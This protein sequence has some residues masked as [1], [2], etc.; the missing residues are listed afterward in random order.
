MT[1]SVLEAPE[2]VASTGVS[3]PALVHPVKYRGDIDGLRA[4][5]V[6]TVI[7]YHL[8]PW[9]LPAGGVGVDI[10]FVISGYLVG[11]MVI[12]SLA[13]GSFSFSDFYLRRIRRILPAFLV[14]ILCTTAV[15]AMPLYPWELT[16]LAKSALA[17]LLCASNI[18]F[19]FTSDYFAAESNT[20]P[21][22]HSWSLG[23]EEQYYI[24]FP[25]VIMAAMKMRRGWINQALAVTI[26]VSLLYSAAQVKTNPVG[27]FY[28]LPS[29]WWELALGALAA[30]APR[31]WF[32]APTVRFVVGVIGLVLMAGSLLLVRPDQG[33]PG[34][35]LLPA[36]TGAALF[37]VSGSAGLSLAHR[38][39]AL[40][41][42]RYTG[43]AS[44]SLYLWHWPIIVLYKQFFF[45]ERLGLREAI[46]ILALTLVLG[47]GSW[48]FV[49]RP[50]RSRMPPRQ[51]L[52]RTGALFALVA[53]LQGT[54]LLGRG[55]PQR[56]PAKALALASMT[57]APDRFPMPSRHCFLAVP[58]TLAQYDPRCL[59][60][61]TGKPDW[62]LVGDSH[63]A[64]LWSGLATNLPQIH[65]QT[66]VVFGCEIYLNPQPD[67]RIC[68]DLMHKALVDHIDQ[69][70]PAA[71]VLTWRWPQ[72]D[73]A[74]LQALFDRL[75]R[76]NVQLIVI[77]PTPE[78]GMAVPR[79]MAESLRRQEPDLLYKN[80][81]P[82][83]WGSDDQLRRVSKRIGFTYLSP[84]TTMCRTD[85]QCDVTDERGNMLYFDNNHYGRLGSAFAI[86]KLIEA[87][88][89]NGSPLA[90]A[91]QSSGASWVAPG[92]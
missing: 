50:F 75:R 76:K 61:V 51:L 67:G 62:L 38:L 80:L 52:M 65:F 3:A 83:I 55:F 15:A 88:R 14:M 5:A 70:P 39:M 35:V 59:G 10:F 45:I 44:Y 78:Y 82:R 13:T 66:A 7:L 25:F 4:L 54:F 68:N 21:L 92:P 19:Y 1:A 9:R 16:S 60:S 41:P 29:R 63:A 43:L 86:R 84:L 11:G 26:L 91:V 2:H 77:G 32:A 27:A 22:L 12:A 37:L 6:T 73:E 49:E 28:L 33:F 69:K 87:D 85:R 42:A 46:P 23:V 79:L 40:A 8:F 34:P 89:A 30:Q 57:E 90:R 31:H 64:M 47:F 36:C 53:L 74:G 20:L 72:V 18:F 81:T 56:F 48:H 17:A 58:D 24:A 71:L